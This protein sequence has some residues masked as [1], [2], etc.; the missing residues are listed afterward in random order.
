MPNLCQHVLFLL[1]ELK[2]HNFLS[3]LVTKAV[4]KTSKP[5]LEVVWHGRYFVAQLPQSQTNL[6]AEADSHVN[7]ELALIQ[8]TLI[9]VNAY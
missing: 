5:P 2:S 3:H 8:R 1:V 7:T 6:N 9:G 4:P